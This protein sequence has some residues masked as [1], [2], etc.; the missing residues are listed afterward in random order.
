MAPS[1]VAAAWAGYAGLAVWAIAARFFHIPAG[2]EPLNRWH[3]ATAHADPAVRGGRLPTSPT[4]VAQAARALGG[5]TAGTFA[6]VA[7][8]ACVASTAL[9][10]TRLDQNGS[11]CAMAADAAPSHAAIARSHTA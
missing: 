11:A 10:A 2:M 5:A 1:A 9:A 4:I 6:G 8:P 3:V 7:R